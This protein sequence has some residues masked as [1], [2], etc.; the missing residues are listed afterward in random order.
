MPPL[1]LDDADIYYKAHGAG[2]PMLFCAATATHGEVWKFYQ[3]PEFSKDHKVITFDQRDAGW[4]PVR[5]IDISNQRRAADA[6]ARLDHVG[7]AP[8]IFCGHSN[9]GRVAQA[10]AATRPDRVS[11]LVLLS[12]GGASKA[13]GITLTVCLDLVRMGYEPWVRNQAIRMG[14]GKAWTAANPLSLEPT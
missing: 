13:S 8:V 4:S 14:F 2:P 5:S 7:G 10:L 6:A 3:I 9:G 11:K 1:R 12:S